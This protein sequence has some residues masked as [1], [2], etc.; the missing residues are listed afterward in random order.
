MVRRRMVGAG[1]QRFQ[2]DP[3]LDGKRHSL[4]AAEAFDHLHF[5]RDKPLTFHDWY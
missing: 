2:N 4:F 5:F 3:P 1:G